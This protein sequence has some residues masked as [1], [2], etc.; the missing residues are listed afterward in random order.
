MNP[1]L[2][3]D[4]KISRKRRQVGQGHE[5]QWLGYISQTGIGPDEPITVAGKQYKF[6][7]LLNSNTDPLEAAEAIVK[8]AQEG[9]S[10][11]NIT[12]VTIYVD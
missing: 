12:C 2:S 10:K 8:A 7:D 6:I 9:G 1:T 11:D 5:D 4:T 3:H